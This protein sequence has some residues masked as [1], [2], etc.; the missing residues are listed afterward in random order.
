MTRQ[1]RLGRRP[2]GDV[3]QLEA[4]FRSAFEDAPIGMAITAI[5]GSFLQVNQALCELLGRSW[6]ELRGMTW[7]DV[8]HPEDRP[9]QEAYEDNALAGQARFFR[10]EKRYVRPDGRTIWALLSRSLVRDAEGNPLVFI[11]Q[12]VDITDRRKVE[13]RIREQE[14]ETRRIIDTAQEAF[15]GMDADGRITDWNRQAELIF[16]WRRDEALGRRLAETVIPERY[17]EAHYRGLARFLD[18]GEATVLGRRLEL[19]ALRRDGSE[20]PVELAIWPVPSGGGVVF[21]ALVHDISDRK[22]AESV[23]RRQKEEL[24]ALH[25]TTLGLLNRLEASDLLETIL[26]R[27]AALLGTP[28]AYL[29]VADPERD[30]LVVRAGTGVFTDYVG[31]RLR[32]GEGLAGR[33]WEGGEPMVVD[34]Y[35]TW[36]G[37]REGFEFLRASVAIPL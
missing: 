33:V 30:E 19:S 18:T 10:T 23:L 1:R 27:A 12:V 20:F 15:V 37:R 21:H 28:H 11:S 13:Q 3:R 35:S 22:E 16:G 17:R 34:D 25:E 26:T 32:R 36:A 5:D 9:V 6:D 31:Y 29:Y 2:D 24:A 8:T 7:A 14:Q 4:L